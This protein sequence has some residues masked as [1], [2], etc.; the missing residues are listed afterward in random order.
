MAAFLLL[1]IGSGVTLADV[2]DWAT[3]ARTLGASATSPVRVGAS[4][5]VAGH[6]GGVTLSVPVSVAGRILPVTAA[7]DGAE[8]GADDDRDSET[9]A[10]GKSVCNGEDQTVVEESPA[11]Q[12]EASVPPPPSL[13]VFSHPS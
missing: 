6:N 13:P 8:A 2:E 9:K 11:A 10:D 5:I 4:P 7:P 1:P 3:R 12:R